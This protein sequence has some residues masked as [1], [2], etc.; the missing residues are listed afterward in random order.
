MATGTLAFDVQPVEN[1]INR[2]EKENVQLFT[3]GSDAMPMNEAWFSRVLGVVV[4]S[5]PSDTHP[6][7]RARAS[8]RL[9]L[10]SFRSAELMEAASAHGPATV[11][12]DR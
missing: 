1:V 7:E 12:R 3:A 2:I 4:I 9:G 10:V 8:R 6:P 5:D 11:E